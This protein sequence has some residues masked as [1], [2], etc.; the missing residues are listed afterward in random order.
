MFAFEQAIPADEFAAKTTVASLIDLIETELADREAINEVTPRL[1]FEA[2]R[3][4]E[5]DEM[6]RARMGAMLGQYREMMVHAVAEDQQ[7]G[8]VFAAAP[9]DAIATLLAAVG[10]GLLLHALLD[11]DLD[12][13]AALRALHA[14]LEPRSEIRRRH[15]S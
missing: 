14:L 6:L 9:A 10:D 12:I 5:R 2:M 11:A 13:R 7:R 1:M 4:A 3:E 8:V 15:R